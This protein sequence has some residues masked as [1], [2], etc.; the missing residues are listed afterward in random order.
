MTDSASTPLTAADSLP[1]LPTAKSLFSLHY[2]H[3]RL[4]EHAEWAAD[5]LPVFETVRALWAR[6]RALG[7][8]WNEAQT[9]QEFVK[10]VLDALGWSYIVQVKAQ[11]RG[12]SLT[13]PDYALFASQVLADEA[14]PHQRTDDAFYGRA[15][16]IAEAKY[17]GRPLSQQ[18]SSGRNTWKAGSNP[19][20]QMVSYLVGT[21]C[22]WGILTNGRTWRLYSREVSSTASE[23]YEV[24]LGLIFDAMPHPTPLAPLPSP[25]LHYAQERGEGWPQAGV[26]GEVLADFKRWWLIFR[27]DAFLPDARGRSFLQQVREGSATYARRVS[28]K[29]KE[30]VFDEVMPEIANGFVAYRRE[31]MGIREET[32]ESLR[33]IYAA[34]LSLLY[35]LLFVL[36]A[37]ARDLLPMR[38]P[39]YREQSLTSLAEWA[40][41][42]AD[43]GLPLSDATFAT[44]RYEA[45]LALFRRID[46]GD[47][48]LG[49]PR[50]D[51]GLFHA[52]TAENQF[53]ERHKLS[54]RVIARAVDIMVRDAGEPVDYA[55]LSVRNLGTIYE[56]LLENKLV[57]TSPPTPSPLPIT[58][59]ERG[60]RGEV[61]LV[62][63]KGE[64]KL[65]GSFYTPDFIVEYIVS[66]TLDPILDERAAR[67]A[68]AMDRL[69]TLRRNLRQA[70]DKGANQRLQAGLADAERAAAEAFLGIKVCDS[71]MGSGHFL[72]NTVDHLTDGIIRRMQVYHDTHPDAPWDWNPVQRLI[73]R[74]RREILEEMARQGITIAA[75]RLD[76][77]ALLT[78]LVMKR[79]I[80]GVDLNPLAV[81]LAKLSLWLHTFTVGAPLSFLDHHLRWGN[82]VIGADVRTVERAMRV[83]DAGQFALFQGPFAGLLDLT[84]VMIEVAERADATLADVQQSAEAYA[85]F[86]RQLLPYKQALDLWVSQWFDEGRKT[87][88]QHP[89]VEFM[90]MHSGDVLPALRGEIVVGE[91][92]QGAIARAREL[93]ERQRFFHWD[94][95]F[96][97]VFIDLAGRDWAAD[98]GFDAMI[99]NPPYVRQEQVSA[100]KRY[101]AAAHAP[102]YDAAA[103]LYVYFYHRGG[104]MLRRGGRLAYIVSNKWLRAGYGEPLRRYLAGQT[105]VERIV[106]FGHAPIFPDADTF[107]CIAVLRKPDIGPAA[108]AETEVCAFPRE[109]LGRSDLIAYVARHSH[110]VPTSRFSA[111]PW[112]LEPPEVDALMM[113]IRRA[114]V[115]L[116]EFIGGKPYR[117]ILTGL[118]EIFLIDTPTR[119]RLIAADLI[120]DKMIVPYLRGQDIKRWHP[121]W[122]NLWMILLKSSEN[123]E[124]PWSR[125]G[126]SAETVFARTFPSLY[127]YLK[128]HEDAL[129]KRQDQGR[130]WW[131][132]RSC[133]YYSA[134][135]RPKIIHT[136]IAWR[137]QFA[138]SDKPVFLVNTAYVWPTSDLY[139]LAV[140]NSPL[141][142]AY[143]WRNAMHGKDEVLRLIYSFTESLP[144]AQPNDPIRAEIEPAVQRLIILK[145]QNQAAMS[146]VLAWLAAEFGVTTPGQVLEAFAE[147]DEASFIQQ[148][149]AR[150]PKGESRLSPAAVG[151]LTR[152]YRQ[153]VPPPRAGAAESVR[154]ES[155]LAELVNTAYGLTPDEVA[156]L[157][158]TAPPRMPVSRAAG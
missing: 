14:Y 102:V 132:L 80:Y 12:G 71:A 8:T 150:R 125:S 10:P 82:S 39:T 90:T 59:E 157:W 136:D 5:S 81:E 99:G 111:A 106:D 47:P 121:E 50:Y 17:W 145:Q 20:H 97:E 119:D 93:W 139:L 86:Q 131:E 55:Y 94:L 9:E 152:V 117:G 120:G 128:P 25:E 13:R 154:L 62:N 15:T 85:A 36:Y 147:S 44:P 32:D 89:A 69:A 149:R 77:T 84:A 75:A 138:Y 127:A 30:L 133:D 4:P 73:E 98:G 72:V 38:S 3:T 58:G 16:A 56:G 141:M 116:L 134:F 87:K 41:E 130:F 114:G 37:E 151:E 140:V 129:R 78:R 83:T 33:Q 70:L 60:G 124:W 66:Q 57:L 122:A 103:D 91:R 76:D 49:L 65:T 64:R 79:C 126:E 63:D 45:L 110:R 48:S 96:P 21:R 135:E 23:F 2:L 18:D 74:M 142:W 7:G 43:R 51:G 92:Y 108:P 29:L 158:R 104:E 115:P 101:L 19:S 35:K 46:R 143:M 11:R 22:P 113:K 105:V 153:Y 40:A 24:D 148:V 61:S 27:R 118:N 54:D 52:A 146:E 112:S 107:P 1:R 31:Q 28:D 155:R 144:I 6:A 88:G 68:A 123:Y 42:R 53:L 137:A 26:R 34:G 67:F 100:T 109:E 156:L 95:E